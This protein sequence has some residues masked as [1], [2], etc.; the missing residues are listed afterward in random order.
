MLNV[1]HI[2]ESATMIIYDNGYYV[3]YEVMKCGKKKTY[4]YISYARNMYTV[5]SSGECTKIVCSL[6]Q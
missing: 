5:I 1:E 2:S 6:T 4:Y 3:A